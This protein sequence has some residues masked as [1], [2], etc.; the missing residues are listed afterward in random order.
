[1]KAVVGK[2]DRHVVAQLL[3]DFLPHG[4]RQVAEVND[5]FAVA[6]DNGHRNAEEVAWARE[7]RAH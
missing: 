7:L 6:E 4:A 2:P 5:A 1:V 3:A